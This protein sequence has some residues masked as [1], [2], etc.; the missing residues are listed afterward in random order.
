[1]TQRLISSGSPWE[2][3]YGYSRAVVAG[4]RVHVSGTCAA[5]P[6]G[7]PPPTDAAAQARR[8]WEI[9]GAALGEAGAALADVVRIRA[10]L[11]RLEDFAA[12]GRV[13]G[14]LLGTIRPTNT[15]V[16]VAALVDPRYLVEIEA[17]ALIPGQPD[18]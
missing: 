13:H 5:M 1:M 18:V 7:A 15:T 14:E 4:N 6:D 8:C 12:V 10:Y 11:T 17:E 2:A 3:A 9:I 16:V